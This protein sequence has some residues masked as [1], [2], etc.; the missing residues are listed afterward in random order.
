MGSA[1]VGAANK[2]VTVQQAASMVKLFKSLVHV[3][4]FICHSVCHPARN[5]KT[6]VTNSSN[7]IT[8][9]QVLCRNAACAQ[10]HLNT[11]AE[12]GLKFPDFSGGNSKLSLQELEHAVP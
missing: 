8:I 2:M 6:V 4:S 12:T 11:F 7:G 9:V 1:P 5:D 10:L 3:S